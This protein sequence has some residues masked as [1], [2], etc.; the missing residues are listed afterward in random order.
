M[1]T[2]D[3]AVGTW[4]NRKFST[5]LPRRVVVEAL[6]RVDKLLVAVRMARGE[7]NKVEVQPVDIG[8]AIFNYLFEPIFGARD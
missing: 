3:I 2:E 8:G 1:I 6:E 5:A 4:R 7:A